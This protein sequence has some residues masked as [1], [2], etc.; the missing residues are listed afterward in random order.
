MSVSKIS[1]KENIMLFMRGEHPHWVPRFGM[2]P[3]PYSHHTPSTAF[4]GPSFLRERRT[5]EG[6]FDIFGVEYTVSAET[7]GAPIPL[8]D[9]FLLDDITKWR[10]IIKVPDISHINWEQMAKKD[11]A[12]VD[13]ENTAVM[14]A[15]HVGFFQQLMAF[16]GFSNGLCAMF[17]E[18][19]E[20]HALFRYMA[21]FYVEVAEKTIEYYKPDIFDLTD[22][23]ATALNPFFSTE[24]YRE[25]VKPYH[26]AQTKPAVDRGLPV[27]IHN[28]G[29]CEDSIED[30]FDLGVTAWNPA[31]VMNDLDGIKKKHGRKLGLIG[32]WD[33]AGPVNWPT[34]TE[35]LIREEVRAV[36]DR[37]APDGGF[38]FWGSTY[39]PIGDEFTENRKRWITEEYESYGRTFYDK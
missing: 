5:P 2:G 7:S 30:W 9:K 12:H 35:E 15:I 1:E 24:M 33:S 37:F 4:M 14:A 29:R 19:E 34:A 28:C 39:G 10:D 6:G 22:D 20:V 38:C 3:D 8:S 36:I 21:D 32:C 27:V 26:Y 25:L 13:R 16:M 31:Q 17:E 18:P 11:L 23:T